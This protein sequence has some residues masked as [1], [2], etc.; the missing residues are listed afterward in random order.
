MDFNNF[1][2]KRLIVN[3]KQFFNVNLIQGGYV[4]NGMPV[5]NTYTYY[6]TSKGMNWLKEMEEEETEE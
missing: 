1:C 2:W 4:K 3:R 5:G 6:I